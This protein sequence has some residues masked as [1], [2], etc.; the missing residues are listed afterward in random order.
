M[1]GT[2]QHGAWLDATVEG[3]KDNRIAGGSAEHCLLVLKNRLAANPGRTG[4]VRPLTEDE[5]R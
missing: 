1:S 5:L 3:A 2:A 4:Y